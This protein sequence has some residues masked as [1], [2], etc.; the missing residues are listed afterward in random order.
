MN[1]KGVLALVDRKYKLI[2]EEAVNE[3]N[4]RIKIAHDEKLE[5][6]KNIRRD[7]KTIAKRM[8]ESNGLVVNNE[9]NFFT[10]SEYYVDYPTIKELINEKA[11]IE[12]EIEKERIAFIDEIIV[13]GIKDKTVKE[14]II[15]LLDVK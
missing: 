10:F 12:K 4:E 6:V 5:I 7:I 3:I 11:E 1:T 14:K 2:K 8:A 9:K 15:S 13:L